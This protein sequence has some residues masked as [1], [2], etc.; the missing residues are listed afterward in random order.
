M[1]KQIQAT[2]HGEVKSYARKTSWVTLV[3]KKLRT[4][5]FGQTNRIHE[6]ICI[7]YKQSELQMNSL[8]AK[9]SDASVF[10]MPMLFPS[11]FVSC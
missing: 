10:L 3:T 8:H 9:E 7:K 5:N 6:N 11:F 1:F 4:S 2:L